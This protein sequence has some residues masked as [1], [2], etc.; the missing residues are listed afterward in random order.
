M[1]LASWSI[2]AQAKHPH[3]PVFDSE[4]GG[5]EC[6]IGIREAQIGSCPGKKFRFLPA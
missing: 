5:L 6:E 2:N 1:L 3:L 4:G